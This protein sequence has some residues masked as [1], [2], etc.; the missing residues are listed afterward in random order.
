MT[1]NNKKQ[2]TQHFLPQSIS[3]QKGAYNRKE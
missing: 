2:G 1:K 3:D